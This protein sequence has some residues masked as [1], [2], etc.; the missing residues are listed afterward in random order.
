MSYSDQPWLE[1][2]GDLVPSV[3]PT[4]FIHPRAVLIGDVT[5]GPQCSIW[6]NATLRGDDG[7]IVLGARCSV[8]DGTVIHMTSNMSDTSVG[9]QVTIGHNVTLHGAKIGSNCIIGMG[10]VVLDNAEIGE[11]SIVGA[12]AIVTMNKKF[13]PGSLILGTPAKVVRSLT[14]KDRE[15]IEYSWKHYIEQAQRYVQ[16]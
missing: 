9:D 3:H 15:W 7:K 12:G 4:A 2:L 5:V 16:R 13:P 11:G 6:P 8:Q 10:S 1:A 14:E